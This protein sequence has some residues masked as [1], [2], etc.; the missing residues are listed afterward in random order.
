MFC[1]PG[2]REQT[3]CLEIR[4][5]HCEADVNAKLMKPVSFSGARSKLLM[6]LFIEP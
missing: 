4:V 1:Q 3:T 2:C 6:S 5:P